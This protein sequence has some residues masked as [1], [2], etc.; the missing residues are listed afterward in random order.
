MLIRKPITICLIPTIFVKFRFK[1]AQRMVGVESPSLLD[2]QKSVD[3]DQES[4]NTIQ[5]MKSRA[6]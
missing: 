5:A 3:R 4:L 6:L 2:H 1:E